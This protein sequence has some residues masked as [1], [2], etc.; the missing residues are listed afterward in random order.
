[1]KPGSPVVAPWFIMIEVSM[2]D[3]ATDLYIQLWRDDMR[4]ARG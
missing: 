2:A 3:T 4:Q 1:M